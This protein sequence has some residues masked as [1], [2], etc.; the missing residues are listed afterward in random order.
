MQTKGA[1]KG[2]SNGGVLRLIN[3][4][5]INMVYLIEPKEAGNRKCIPFCSALCGIKPLYGVPPIYC[6]TVE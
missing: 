4:R 3:L 5:R 2:M 1:D 6:Y